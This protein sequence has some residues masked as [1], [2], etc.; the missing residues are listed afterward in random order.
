[1]PGAIRRILMNLTGNSLKHT[2]AGFVK[3]DL[4]LRETVSG[5]QKGK[6]RTAPRFIAIPTV[7]DM[8]KRHIPGVSGDKLNTLFSQ[9][10]K[11]ATGPG[12]DLS[13]ANDPVKFIG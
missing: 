7:T 9:E 12:P 13:M 11:P 3:I 1:M 10:S 8:G 6:G 2:Q 5:H 4:A